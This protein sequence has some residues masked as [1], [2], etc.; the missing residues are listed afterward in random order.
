[1]DVFVPSKPGSEERRSHVPLMW[2]L[3]LK[4]KCIH[5]HTQGLIDIYIEHVLV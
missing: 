5:K 1:M 4:D 3:D 2:K